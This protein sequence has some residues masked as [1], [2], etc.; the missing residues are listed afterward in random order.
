MIAILLC[1]KGGFVHPT[2]VG[3]LGDPTV[4]ISKPFEIHVIL[5]H[6]KILD[7]IRFW[8]LASQRMLQT[9]T[10]V[11]PVALE[12]TNPAKLC[13]AASAASSCFRISDADTV[14][15]FMPAMDQSVA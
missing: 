11:G 2:L 6:L 8:I 1:R 12:I 3:D 7:G 4:A 10:A 14:S 13:I 15:A 5:R 9:F